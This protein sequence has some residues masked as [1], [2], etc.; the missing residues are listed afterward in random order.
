MSTIH[1]AN[2]ADQDKP[3]SVRK[4][5][6][7]K[8]R[9]G[10]VYVG[11]LICILGI[12]SVVLS[13]K[14]YVD[15]E[16]VTS[17]QMKDS[18]ESFYE[19]FQGKLI[20]YSVDGISYLDSD[21]KAIWAE[22]FSMKTPKISLSENYITVADI[23]GNAVYLFDKKGK[24]GNYTMAYPI[25]DIET[26]D[27]G[28]FGV[29]L[30]DSDANFIH[31]YDKAGE[32]LMGGKMSMEENGYPLD[33][34]L[35]NDG[36]KVIASYV[37]IDG[38]TAKNTLAFYNFTSV[39]QN[40]NSNWLVG[41]YNF[42]DSIFPKTVFMD[43]D[44]ICAFGDNESILYSMKET[45]QEKKK[46]KFKSDISSIFY[47]DQYIGY[48]LQKNETQNNSKYE[49]QVYNIKGKQVFSQDLD[50]EYNSVKLDGKDIIL[51]GDNECRIY[52]LNGTMKFKGDFKSQITNVVPTG[53]YHQYIV[54]GQNETQTIKLR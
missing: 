43:N 30:E 44:I 4:R 1:T 17:V 25:C 23:K 47:S 46:I 28:V 49:L 52:S 7:P 51:V 35:S 48:V 22:S 33:I 8:I 41:A 18:V 13:K 31:I 38:I 37:A 34:G 14:T 27:Q 29:V 9:R 36:K 53:K 2:N 40:A 6:L 32:E 12:I 45:P 54:I 11:V 19:V 42:T 16:V 21:G 50:M 10:F 26:A 20:K 24:V 39:G 15:Y 5:R 3:A